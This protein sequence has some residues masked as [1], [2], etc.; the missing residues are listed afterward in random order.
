[1]RCEDLKILVKE[2]QPE[3]KTATVEEYGFA[4]ENYLNGIIIIYSASD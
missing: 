2:F 4:L 3:M 1:M